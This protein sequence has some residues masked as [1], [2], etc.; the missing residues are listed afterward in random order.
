VHSSPV[1]RQHTA[2]ASATPEP[3][4]ELLTF[5]GNYALTHSIFSW[6]PDPSHYF[7]CLVRALSAFDLH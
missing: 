4:Q 2:D 7:D 1:W 5:Q 3:K 6:R